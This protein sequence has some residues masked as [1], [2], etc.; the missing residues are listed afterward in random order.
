MPGSRSSPFRWRGRAAA[1]PF[2][3]VATGWSLFR[4]DGLIALMALLR[5]L[6]VEGR[7]GMGETECKG[8]YASTVKRI[9]PDSR[10]ERS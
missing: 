10:G 5:D 2:V 9:M 6:Q 8:D 4:V 3:V 7:A 1:D